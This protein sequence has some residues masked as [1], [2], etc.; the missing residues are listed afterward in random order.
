[1]SCRFQFYFCLKDEETSVLQMKFSKAVEFINGGGGR[2]NR[3]GSL[4]SPQYYAFL[5]KMS[6]KQL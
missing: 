5:V 4:S 2:E 1:M 6:G 3:V